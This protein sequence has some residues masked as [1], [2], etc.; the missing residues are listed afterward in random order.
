MSG[1]PLDI[2]DL[3]HKTPNEII[4]EADDT[5]FTK[6]EDHDPLKDPVEGH[7][8]GVADNREGMD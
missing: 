6:L 7:I 4:D 8:D 3:E 2:N 5:D 1:K